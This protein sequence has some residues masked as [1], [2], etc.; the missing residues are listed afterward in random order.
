MEDAWATVFSYLP[1]RDVRKCERVCSMWR[2]LAHRALRQLQVINFERDFPGAIEESS[3]VERILG[4]YCKVQ[5]RYPQVE[6]FEQI[7][8]AFEQV[9]LIF[10][11]NISRLRPKNTR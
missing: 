7:T 10:R 11:R 8:C 2:R 3:R 9:S 1:L 5:Q 6:K 4:G